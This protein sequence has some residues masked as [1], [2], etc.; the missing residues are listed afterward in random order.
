MSLYSRFI[1]QINLTVIDFAASLIHCFAFKQLIKAQHYIWFT[2]HINLLLREESAK[3]SWNL[4]AGLAT[5]FQI[6]L[7]AI[8]YKLFSSV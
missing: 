1:S 6:N 8:D 7:T 5:F 4:C 2:P 3:S